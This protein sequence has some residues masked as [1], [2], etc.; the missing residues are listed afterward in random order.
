ML[1]PRVE[2]ASFG[3]GPRLAAAMLVMAFASPAFGVSPLLSAKCE[4]ELE[5]TRIEAVAVLAPVQYDFT[6]TAAELTSVRRVGKGRITTGLTVSRRSTRLTAAVSSLASSNGQGCMRP[7]IRVELLLAEHTVYVAREFPRGTCSHRD[8]LQHEHVHVRINEQQL[9]EVAKSLQRDLRGY[10][11]NRIFYGEVTTLRANLA[12]SLEH[13]WLERAEWRLEQG[14]A[15]HERFDRE[16]LNES[17]RACSQERARFLRAAGV[18]RYARPP[19]TSPAAEG[20]V[21]PRVAPSCSQ[22][23]SDDV[24]NYEDA[25]SKKQQ[26]RH[27]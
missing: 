24:D 9:Q 10:L 2:M 5:P 13:D 7:Q 23:A 1:A 15:D 16:Q 4:R 27:P 22:Q 18:N 14:Q 3:P 20:L 12:K 8:T 17:T 6:K 25:A 19:A 26:R 21:G 11:G